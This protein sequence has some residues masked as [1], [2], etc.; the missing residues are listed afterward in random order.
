MFRNRN[1][2]DASVT[3]R[4]DV[5]TTM[6]AITART[7]VIVRIAANARTAGSVPTSKPP[8]LSLTRK[9]IYKFIEC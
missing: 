2:D 5:Q 9:G 1:V 4:M 8:I 7:S 6:V 3:V